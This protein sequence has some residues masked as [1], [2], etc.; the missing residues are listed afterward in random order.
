MLDKV[1]VSKNVLLL[2]A[3][4]VWF[5]VGAMLVTVAIF[6]ISN[7]P[8]LHDFLFAGGGVVIAL[9]AHHFGFLRI[10]DKN[11]KRILPMDKKSSPFSFVPWKSYITI[12]FMVGLGAFLRHSSVP[13]HYLAV[14]YIG[15]GLALILS[16]VR[17]F[18]IFVAE[19]R[20]PEQPRSP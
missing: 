3:G 8:H 4:I 14:V 1:R 11:V 10:V 6:W 7:G 20:R 9:L 2:L 13:K 5:A 19:T 15:I 18:R 17:Y 12:V 16:S